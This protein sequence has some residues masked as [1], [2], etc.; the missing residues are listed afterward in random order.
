MNWTKLKRLPS[1]SVFWNQTLSCNFA[2][3]HTFYFRLQL[4]KSPA[5][6]KE[7]AVASK[8]EILE[9]ELAASS[10]PQGSSPGVTIAFPALKASPANA[11]PS[12]S[13][14]PKQRGEQ[15]PHP[16][17]RSP[18]SELIALSGTLSM[19]ISDTDP[20]QWTVAFFFNIHAVCVDY[21]TMGLWLDPTRTDS[22]EPR[23][24]RNIGSAWTK[25]R[26]V[27]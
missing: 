2:T 15:D 22:L 4:S 6:E 24:M 7:A 10:K 25:S 23:G 9:P 13:S 1:G 12:V 3:I 27:A 11:A 19:P 21:G 5:P 14:T 17:D 18:T 20:H 8:T 16:S 26:G